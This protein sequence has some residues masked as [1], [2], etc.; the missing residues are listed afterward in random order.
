MEDLANPLSY[1]RSHVVPAAAEYGIAV[2]RTPMAS[3]VSSECE[4]NIERMLSKPF[5]FKTQMQNGNQT[6]RKKISIDDWKLAAARDSRRPTWVEVARATRATEALLHQGE[7]S[8]LQC[9]DGNAS[10]CEAEDSH[11]FAVLERSDVASRPEYASELPCH[12]GIVPSYIPWSP[13]A[14]PLSPSSPLR[15]LA[16]PS[17]GV[18]APQ[19]FVS[20]QYS[21]FA[22][23]TEDLD[24]F[25]C[26]ILHQGASKTW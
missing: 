10:V 5:A 4:S 6:S 22:W 8:E 9:S 7:S 14:L 18:N 25:S 21:F 3:D 23:H 12:D 15:L 26:N 19:L 17:S 16:Y 11:F 1:I 20:R 2:I 24:L 13:A